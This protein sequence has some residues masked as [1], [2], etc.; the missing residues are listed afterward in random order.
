MR[1][2]YVRSFMSIDTKLVKSFCP[3]ERRQKEGC[4]SV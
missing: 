4:A 2:E 1:C 3:K